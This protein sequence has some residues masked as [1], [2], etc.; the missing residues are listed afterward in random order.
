MPSA[1]LP[2]TSAVCCCRRRCA[3]GACW[4]STPASAPAASLPLSMT[5]APDTA[6]SGQALVAGEAPS[7][8]QMTGVS[9]D[10]PA[11]EGPPPAPPV[12]TPV[13]TAPSPPPPTVDPSLPEP[14]PELAYVI[15]NEAGASVYS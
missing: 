14:L 6:A 2:A 15:V 13:Q 3:A 9:A 12:H 7:V 4:P 11:G 1:F 10:K 5:P 8:A